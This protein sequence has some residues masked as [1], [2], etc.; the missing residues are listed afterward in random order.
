MKDLEQEVLTLKEGDAHAHFHGHEKCTHDHS[1]DEE[2]HDDDQ[3]MEDSHEH[4]HE[5]KREDHEHAHDHGTCTAKHDHHEHEHAH[6]HEHSHGHGGSCTADHSH[7][8]HAHHH[9]DDDI[10]AWKK[11]AMDSDPMAAP[12]GGSWNTEASVDATAPQEEMAP[13]YTGDVEDYDKASNAKQEAADLK[14]TG[15]YE[16]A[17]AKFSEAVLAAPPS[18]LLLANRAECLLKLDR[19]N[20]AIRDAKEALKLNPDSA[21]AL[22]VLGKAQFQLNMWKEARDNLSASQTID[23]D[24]SVVELLK[25]ATHKVQEMESNETKKRLEDEAKLRKRAQEIKRARE[26]AAKASHAPKPSARSASASAAGMGGMPDMGGMPG[27]PAGMQG[28]MAALMSD[29]EL[30]EGMKNPKV[31]AAFQG[32][33]SAPGGAMGLLSNPAKLQELMSDPDVGPFMKKLMTKLGPMMGGM[34]GGMP[35]FGGGGAPRSSGADDDIE[36][37]PMM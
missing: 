3:K 22:K 17:L 7:D 1:H 26:E 30:A 5:H 31:Q 29:P 8:E 6:G 23:F 15:D 37:V 19:A 14:A 24:D 28:M 27:M 21:K 4:S 9:K 10:P 36:D 33:M 32:L 20:A 34:G 12:F 16:G 35:P 25:E 2:A 18:A 11:K 13:L